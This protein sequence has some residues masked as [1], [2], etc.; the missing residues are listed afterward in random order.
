MRKNETERTATQRRRR[1]S[2]S[3]KRTVTLEIERGRGQRKSDS[4]GTTKD[5]NVAEAK[6]RS[7]T[8]KTIR[9]TKS[10]DHKR[11]NTSEKDP[12]R[13]KETREIIDCT[14]NPL[15]EDCHPLITFAS[16]AYNLFINKFIHSRYD[17]VQLYS[18]SSKC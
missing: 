7:V 18:V 5:L 17:V 1:K 6:I 14:A 11:S 12:A 2:T 3:T 8:V 4:N 15:Y 13:E 16:N 10:E 9:K